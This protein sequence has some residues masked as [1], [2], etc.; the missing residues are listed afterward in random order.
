MLKA[1]SRVKAG[2][3]KYVFLAE[4]WNADN[5]DFADWH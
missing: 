5:T 2:Q 1:L 4:K 3:G